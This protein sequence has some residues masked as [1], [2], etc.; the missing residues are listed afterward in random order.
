MTGSKSAIR[1]K[2]PFPCWAIISPMMPRIRTLADD[3]LQPESTPIGGRWYERRLDEQL[4][5]IDDPAMTKSDARLD[6]EKWGSWVNGSGNPVPY[7]SNNP[8][9]ESMAESMERL[10]N[11]YLVGR[12]VEIYNNQ[13]VGNA[14]Q[15]P[16]PQT[17][18]DPTNG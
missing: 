18:L 8:D 16:T 12:R 2:V 9:V 13:T 3:F 11:E 7:T 5:L 14:G 4:A 15:I 10:K 1:M 6:F 17:G